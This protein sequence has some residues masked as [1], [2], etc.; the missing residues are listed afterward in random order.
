MLAVETWLTGKECVELGFAD[1]LAEPLVA[2]ASIQ[3][4]KNRGFYQY[5]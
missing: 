4:K 5:A 3:S 2:M 1:K